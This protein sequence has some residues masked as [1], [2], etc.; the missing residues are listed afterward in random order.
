MKTICSR[1][2]S[3]RARRTADGDSGVTLIELTV[4][5][6]LTTILLGVLIAPLITLTHVTGSTAATSQAT[7]SARTAVQDMSAA[8][9]SASQICLPTQLTS[10]QTATLGSAVRVK[11][12]VFG[13]VNGK[14]EQWWVKPLTHQLLAQSWTTTAPSPTSWRTV[15][16]NVSSVS[17]PRSPP[18]TPF[19][20]SP[21]SGR[22]STTGTL[23]ARDY[24]ATG[25]TSDGT[26]TGTWTYTLHVNNPPPA[27]TIV[28]AEPTSG[29]VTTTGSAAFTDQLA[30]TGSTGTVTYTK[31]AGSA[32]LTVTSIGLVATTGALAAGDY[33]ATGTTS[34]SNL[35]PDTGTWTYTLHVYTTAAGTIAQTKPTSGTVTTTGSATFTDQLAV[36]G[37]TGTVTYTQTTGGTSLT[38]SALPATNAAV[39]LAIAITASSGVKSTAVSVPFTSAITALDTVFA[40]GTGTCMVGLG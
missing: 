32:S 34:D 31:S 11:T 20:I 12:N 3:V 7:A 6:L 16:N 28:Q 21:T 18:P 8:V 1:V 4:T 10:T 36:T 40:P 27:G 2:R 13:A 26:G 22:I 25:T 14:W 38:L 35:P 15:A 33:T 30:V 19:T 24:T 9:T 29:T 39:V 37:N 5:M 17:A 23:T